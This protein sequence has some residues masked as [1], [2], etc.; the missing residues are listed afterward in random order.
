[1][2]LIFYQHEKHLYGNV[3]QRQ[4]DKCHSA[5]SR[6]AAVGIINNG[7][8]KPM[9]NTV[10]LDLL[11]LSKGIYNLIINKENTFKSIKFNIIE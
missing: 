4:T 9:G 5:M 7:K 10:L 1:M 8:C 2:E 6:A 11:N 3:C